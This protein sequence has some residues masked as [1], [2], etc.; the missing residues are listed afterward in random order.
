MNFV[1]KICAGLVHFVRAHRVTMTMGSYAA[2]V[3]VAVSVHFGLTYW[4]VRT[5]PGDSVPVLGWFELGVWALFAVWYIA[6]VQV[7]RR[8][9]ATA[10]ATTA[11]PSRVLSVVC[12]CPSCEGEDA[13]D[14][15]ITK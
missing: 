11:A 15:G 3:G 7:V 8:P 5:H 14:S 1:R 10:V 2:M 9:A 4:I 6:F 12:D 13:P